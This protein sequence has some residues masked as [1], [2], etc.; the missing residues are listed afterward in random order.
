MDLFEVLDAE[1]DTGVTVGYTTS[2][3]RDIYEVRVRDADLFPIKG[4]IVM[5]KIYRA[6]DESFYRTV[7]A[8][9]IGHALGM[10]HSTDRLHLMIGS[11]APV[12][13]QPSPDEIWL[14]KVMYHLPRGIDMDTFVWD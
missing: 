13:S 12:V 4:T 10:A 5:R 14:G 8:H 11:R 9:E 3:T 7:V 2:N 1:P 6:S